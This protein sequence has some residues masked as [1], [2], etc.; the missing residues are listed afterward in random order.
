MWAHPGRREGAGRAWEQ[1]IRAG[2]SRFQGEEG[3]RAPGLIRAG[4][5]R[6][7]VLS[8]LTAPM[9]RGLSTAQAWSVSDSVTLGHWHTTVPQGCC[10]WD[11]TTPGGAARVLGRAPCS[12]PEAVCVCP[13]EGN[14]SPGSASPTPSTLLP[15]PCSQCR[16]APP[17][18]SDL[19]VLVLTAGGRM[20]NHPAARALVPVLGSVLKDGLALGETQRGRILRR[21][22]AWLINSCAKP[23]L[24]WGPQW[25]GAAGVPQQ[26][27]WSW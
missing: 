17:P 22:W 9:L 6:P 1:E 20:L 5:M 25:L 26:L 3:G 24:V 10:S 8:G 15:A 2:R 16:A 13:Q 19:P 23:W 18:A 14:V 21:R 12:C 27:A 11:P 4:G 7:G